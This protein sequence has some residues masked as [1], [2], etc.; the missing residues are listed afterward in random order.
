MTDGI[1]PQRTATAKNRGASRLLNT[2]Q[3]VL[4]GWGEYISLVIH[5]LPIIA[6]A[7]RTYLRLLPVVVQKMMRYLS[8]SSARGGSNKRRAWETK[9]AGRRSLSCDYNLCF[10]SKLD[11]Y[12]MPQRQLSLSILERHTSTV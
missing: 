7:A 12:S 10:P 3:E 9:E 11:N 5:V 1:Y 2:V 4:R 6:V 8:S